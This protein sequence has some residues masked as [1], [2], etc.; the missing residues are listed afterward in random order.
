MNQRYKSMMDKIEFA[1]D[2]KKDI[3]K[4]LEM[5]KCYEERRSVKDIWIYAVG[6]AAMM[7]M[8]ITST[9]FSSKM[10]YAAV[11]AVQKA[12]KETLN[13][14]KDVLDTFVD[15]MKEIYYANDDVEIVQNEDDGYMTV[16]VKEVKDYIEVVD[17]K[18]IFFYG[19]DRIDIT[20]MFDDERYY[21]YIVDDVYSI[22]VGGEPDNIG[23][24]RVFFTD[25][26]G[27]Y[28]DYINGP[29]VDKYSPWQ[30]NV[31]KSIDE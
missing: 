12:V 7:A 26:G 17:D 5:H 14:S 22:Y 29:I 11:E 2:T 23:L 3:R 10:T 6:M 9:W 1:D 18:I 31:F 15:E 25:D 16:E 13:S 20:G 28:V 30:K 4:S 24:M 8:V 27:Y 21:Q 19:E